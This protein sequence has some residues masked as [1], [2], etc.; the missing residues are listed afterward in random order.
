MTLLFATPP[1]AA[2]GADATTLPSSGYGLVLIL[3]GAVIQD[4]A[5]LLQLLLRCWA[6]SLFVRRDLW[7][8]ASEEEKE[9]CYWEEQ[10]RQ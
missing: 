5:V 9:G 2:A 6:P 1:R 10:D 4:V 3:E 7:K 8:L